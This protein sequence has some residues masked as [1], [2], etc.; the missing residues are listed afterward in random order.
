VLVALPNT[1]KPVS[2]L[3]SL[4]RARPYVRRARGG[5]SGI[6]REVERGEGRG[7]RGGWRVD[8]YSI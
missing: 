2:L 6:V 5:E 7:E 1:N 4:A 3:G 8:E